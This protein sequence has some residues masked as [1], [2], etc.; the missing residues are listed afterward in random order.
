MTIPILDASVLHAGSEAQRSKFG[1]QFLSGFLEHG[2]V[3]LV[4]HSLS[5]DKISN[6]FRAVSTYKLPRIV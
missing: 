5:E 2:V 3:K 4:N 6:V 1:Q